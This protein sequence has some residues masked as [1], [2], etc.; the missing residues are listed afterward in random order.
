M[1]QK[2]KAI[3]EMIDS[4]LE[5]TSVPKNIRKALSDAKG[6]LNGTDDAIVKVSA[7]IYLIEPVSEDVNMP[8]HA[9]TQ[10]WAIMSSLES[11]KR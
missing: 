2:I 6:R 9:R 1:E 4:V 8:A 7:A 11:I 10:I 3:I 5:D